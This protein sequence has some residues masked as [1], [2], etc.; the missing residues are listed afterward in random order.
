MSERQEL[1]EPLNER[2]QE[3]LACLI[4]GLSNREIAS[5]LHLAYR[6]VKWYNTQIYGK[7][8]V[9]NRDDA[10]AR[11]QK[12]GL[13]NVDDG[14]GIAMGK[15]NLPQTAT[16]FIG[17]HDEIH[18]LLD[19]LSSERL[20][21][22]L[23]PGG[24]GKTRLSLEVARRSIG[25]HRDGVY[26]V[27]LAPLSSPD[28]IVTTIAE[29][30]GFVFHGDQPPETQLINFLK[31]RDMLLILDNFEHL[32]D[33]AGLIS[34]IVKSAGGIHMLI[35]SR[36]R[37]N[38]RGE[39]VYSLRGLSF[40]T[41]ETPA[42]ALEYDAVKLFIGGARR[43]RPDFELIAD[44]LDYLARICKLTQGMP[45]GI[46]LAAGWVDILSLEQISNEIQQSIDILETD[47]RDMPERH[48][49]LRASFE[50]TW[51]RLTDTE[52]DVFT[53]LSV[54]RGGFT[55]ASAEAVAGANPRH[56]RKLAQKALIQTEP[57]D[58]YGIHELLRQFGE[59]KLFESGEHSII[60]RSYAEFFANVVD[61][62][63]QRR[64]GYYNF[65][66]DTKPVSEKIK[67]LSELDNIKTVWLFYIAEKNLKQL[68]LMLPGVWRIFDET[69]RYHDAI[70]V[71][72]RAYHA[73]AD[74]D[75]PDNVL[76][77]AQL[78]V[79]LA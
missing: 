28:D 18:D 19:L 71:L 50:R 20:I 79:R 60:E 38:L 37:L 69:S 40:P 68:R 36:E 39:V 51:N 63:G 65:N 54:F 6:T 73:F 75:D 48:R 34:D 14:D 67:V 46:E 59:M 53:K 9:N 64:W 35:T 33:G 74:S 56:I 29:N 66:D 43:T 3:I 13:I 41:C 25:K 2:E 44:D 61:L 21:T 76:F 72:N 77:R 11:A 42:D 7:L 1:V 4:E 22:I 8:G 55:L 15:H 52:Q 26:F 23:A 12:L 5:K 17:R 78:T 32:M 45:L 24:M 10:V 70:T 30:I 57:N 31:E 27:P 47:M 58:R 62:I 49:S 16:A